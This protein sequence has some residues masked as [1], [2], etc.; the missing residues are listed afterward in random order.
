MWWKVALGGTQIATG[1]MAN[2]AARKAA[3]ENSN[4][5]RME[6]AENLRRMDRQHL[7]RVGEAKAWIGASGLLQTGSVNAALNNMELEYMRQ[8]QWV[9]DTGAQR[10]RIAGKSG[11]YVGMN[12][13]FQGIETLGSAWTPNPQVQQKSGSDYLNY[14]QRNG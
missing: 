6:T 8:R 14:N 9:E 13:I 4:L 1:L 10:A 5:I 3:K 12:Q 11:Q 2:R 7:F